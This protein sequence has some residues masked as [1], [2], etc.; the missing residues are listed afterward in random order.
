MA[1]VRRQTEDWLNEGQNYNLVLNLDRD[2]TGETIQVR[3]EEVDIVNAGQIVGT[4]NGDSANTDI[5]IPCSFSSLD[6]G[7]YYL[8]AWSEYGTSSQKVEY[9]NE[10][11]Q[12]IINIGNRFGDS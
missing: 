6:D 12:H 1:I 2:T 5:I 7:R 9:P 4:A 11:E 3:V 8:E 10:N